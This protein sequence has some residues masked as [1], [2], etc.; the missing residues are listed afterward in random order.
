MLSNPREDEPVRLLLVTN[1]SEAY[2]RALVEGASA[3]ARER[4]VNLVVQSTGSTEQSR[5]VDSNAVVGVSGAIVSLTAND[6]VLQDLRRLWAL[7]DVVTCGADADGDSLIHVGTNQYSAGRICGNVVREAL[8]EGG[9]VVALTDDEVATTRLAALEESL[10]AGSKERFTTWR[11]V[12]QSTDGAES[13]EARLSDVLGDDEVPTCVIDLRGSVSSGSTGELAAFAATR[14]IKF[15][16]FDGST[17]ALAAVETGEALAVLS[18]DAFAQGY[19]AVQ[20]LVGIC[21]GNQWRRP[22]P[23]HG[24][25]HVPVT[26]VR[27]GN[28]AEHRAHLLAAVRQPAA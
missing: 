26:V 28:V 20:H 18:E 9:R 14:G 11:V 24:R 17:D 27:Q 10:R 12:A 22:A 4:G 2:G 25:V 21:Q 23:G 15:I 5:L 16:T 6:E 19:Q 8:P 1:A 7:T 3:A 13:V